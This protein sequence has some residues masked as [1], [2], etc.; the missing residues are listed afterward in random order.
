[1]VL[2]EY[3]QST[4]PGLI[5]KPSLY[6]QWN[7]GIHIELAKGL[8][9]F[10]FGLDELNPSYFN[11]VHEQ[12]LSLF[13]DIFSAEDK[14]FLVTNMYHHKDYIRRCRRKMKVYRH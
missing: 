14:I 13:N 7:T 5:L 3:L 12:C 4:F 11:R 9:P 10:K 6:H 8:S 2:K 1:M